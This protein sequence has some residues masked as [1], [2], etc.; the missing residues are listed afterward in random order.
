MFLGMI[1]LKPFTRMQNV[2]PLTVQRFLKSSLSGYADSG[3]NLKVSICITSPTDRCLNTYNRLRDIEWMMSMLIP[4]NCCTN[5]R[6][7]ISAIVLH[8]IPFFISK[9]CVMCFGC[10]YSS[11]TIQ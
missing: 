1:S 11:N 10:P 8:T 5:P 4:E 7:H 9:K 2:Y 3:G 6:M